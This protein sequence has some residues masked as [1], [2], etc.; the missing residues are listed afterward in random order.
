[1]S[2]S[3]P[4]SGGPTRIDPLNLLGLARS[5]GE[6]SPF[7]PITNALLLGI[8]GLILAIFTGLIDLAQAITSFFSRPIFAGGAGAADIV[9]AFLGGI[10]NIIITGAEV[11]AFS[12]IPGPFQ[13]PLLVP[14][15]AFIYAVA[16]V[17]GAAFVMAL[18]LNRFVT[19]DFVPGT[20]TDF[21]VV[22]QDEDEE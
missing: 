15:F 9:S 13:S 19:S 20:G 8:T 2:S 18:V 1:M 12:L 14:I 7:G 21:P 3:D 4:G 17:G 16:I 11:T 5:L 6:N 10:A 22:G